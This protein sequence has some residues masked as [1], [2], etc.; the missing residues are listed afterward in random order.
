MQTHTAHR[1]GPRRNHAA[2]RCCTRAGS[3]GSASSLA[4]AKEIQAVGGGPRASNSAAQRASA[5][6]EKSATAMDSASVGNTSAATLGDT[7]SGWL[8]SNSRQS[9][10]PS[11]CVRKKRLNQKWTGADA[12]GAPAAARVTGWL[13]MAAGKP[14]CLMRCS[15]PIDWANNSASTRHTSAVAPW[16]AQGRAADPAVA[17]MAARWTRRR[18]CMAKIL[19]RRLGLN[20]ALFCTNSGNRHACSRTLCELADRHHRPSPGR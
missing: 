19:I 6:P 3:T 17:V 7:P 15:W 13:C 11:S 8:W 16:L 12:V 9:G 20:S 2:C 10:L 14:R 1:S 5:A 18:R 4:A